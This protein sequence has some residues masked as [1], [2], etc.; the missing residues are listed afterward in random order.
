MSQSLHTAADRSLW[1]H[2]DFML[3]WAGQTVSEVGSAITVLALPLVAL[4]TLDASTFAVAA[5]TAATNVA[6]LL[7]ALPAGAWVDRWRKRRVLVWGDIGRVL[8]LGSIPVANAFD[9]L[10]LPQLYVVAVLT[11]VLTVFFDVAYQSY[12]PE[13]V[14]P[15][16]LVDGNGKIG[17]SQAFGQVAGPSFGGVLVGALGAAYAVI[18][19]AA[20]FAVSAVATLAIRRPDVRPE[21]DP[22]TRDFRREIR[23]GLAFVLGHPILRKIVGCT[24]TSNFFSGAMFSIETVYLYRTL[25]ASPGVI[26]LVLAAGSVGGLVGGVFARRIAARVGS[27]RVIWLSQAV[28]G[29]FGFI[30]VFAFPGWGVSLVAISFFAF[31]ASGVVYNTAQVSYR[32]AISP[33]ALLGRMNASVRF[34]VWGTLPLGALAGGLLGTLI[35]LR[36]TVAVCAAGIWAASLWVVFSPLFGM[37]DV[38]VTVD[39]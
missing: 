6:F 13:L 2:R 4:V 37:R 31:S 26:G 29:P 23:E 38:P 25:H 3:L 9:M 36:A 16:Q 17:A 1:R 34:L 19:D 5:L 21:P 20:S 33:R 10:G 22:E 8:L 39:G 32:Q 35:G 24:G 7:V 18:V 14:D 12:L 28:A 30:A 15:D 11:G 27:A